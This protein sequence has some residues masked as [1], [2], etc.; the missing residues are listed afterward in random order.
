M[1]TEV[2]EHLLDP[3]Y[4]LDCFAGLLKSGGLCIVSLPNENTV[5]HR[6]YSVL[7]YGID[8]CAFADYGTHKHLHFPTLS[9][10]RGFLSSRFIID[11]EEYYIDPSGKGSR[12]SFIGKLFTA[13][14]DS[15]WYML[16]S[17]LPS[18]FARGGVWRLKLK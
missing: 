9:Q 11:V 8:S 5:F 4:Y 17:C 10:S 15:F 18:L 2:L 13:L 16:S 12:F 6:L 1:C 14:P 7:G 3:A